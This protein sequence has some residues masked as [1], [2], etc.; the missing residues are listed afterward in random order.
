MLHGWYA[1]PFNDQM[2]CL[3]R[4][5]MM[6]LWGYFSSEVTHMKMRLRPSSLVKGGLL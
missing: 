5:T 1:M 6:H 3:I 4:T 2:I